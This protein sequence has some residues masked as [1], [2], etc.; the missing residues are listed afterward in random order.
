[1]E[2]PAPRTLN[3]PVGCRFSSFRKISAGAS[4]TFKR[5]SGVRTT[6][7]SIRLRADS[8]AA[9]SRRFNPILHQLG[10]DAPL[11]DGD[12]PNRYPPK[13]RPQTAIGYTIIRSIP[14][15]PSPRYVFEM[16]RPRAMRETTPRITEMNWK[17]GRTTRIV[18]IAERAMKT[19]VQSETSEWMNPESSVKIPTAI[20]PR[21]ARAATIDRSRSRNARNR[22][23]AIARTMSP[24]RITEGLKI[25]SAGATP[26]SLIAFFETLYP[27]GTGYVAS[28]MMRPMIR[29]CA[30]P[31][32][33]SMPAH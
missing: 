16:Y 21:P 12:I 32:N 24:R 33:R 6:R 11:E 10:T 2:L 7:P 14:P 20:A 30:V 22:N 23:Q 5:T 31:T 3:D 8:I 15:G 9:R 19:N 17:G 28:A 13:A 1:M 26:R 4:S 25:G 18:R 29:Y 27:G